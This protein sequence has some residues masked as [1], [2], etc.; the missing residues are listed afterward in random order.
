MENKVIE[1]ER[2]AAAGRIASMV[3]HDLR[4]PLQTIKNSLFLM[5]ISPERTEEF[6]K[7]ANDAI[8]Y[9]VDIIED[10]RFNTRD[11]TP[12]KQDS[13][14]DYLVEKAVSEA[15]VPEN[16]N[17]QLDIKD[18][19]KS[20]SIDPTQIRRV[21]DNLIRNAVEAMPEG[22]ELK[23][24]GEL[25]GDNVTL[26][27]SDTG[28]GIPEDE[29]EKLFT[30]FHTTKPQGMGLGLVYCRRAVE[31]HGG[32]IEVDSTAGVGTKITVKLPLKQGP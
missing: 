4:G 6:K 11:I 16:V 1:A 8:D 20:V 25:K 24:K 23:V 32:S 29:K 19:L 3:G 10:L 26:S 7:I 27:V 12:N 31:A 5:E 14:L 15:S 9:A 2:I 30:P 22:G 17:V 21:L 18:G 13:N 28:V